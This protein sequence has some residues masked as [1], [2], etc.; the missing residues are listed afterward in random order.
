MSVTEQARLRGERL[1]AFVEAAKGV[2]AS[3]DDCS[4]WPAQ[5]VANEGG[6]DFDWPRFDDLAAMEAYVAEGGGLVAV[7]E[8]FAP[9]AG[10]AERYMVDDTAVGDIG[11]IETRGGRVGGIFSHAG[12]FCWRTQS[13]VNLIGVGGRS[14]WE[15]NA[16]GEWEQRPVVVKVWQVPCA[17]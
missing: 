3:V 5:W 7:W 4:A 14:F 16:A 17:R 13:G 1:R 9:A 6:R 8:R 15:R 12:V 11:I 10:I 2:P